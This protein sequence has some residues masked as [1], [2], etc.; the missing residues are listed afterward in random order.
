MY[1]CGYN[2][3]GSQ[4]DVAGYVI[5]NGATHYI[6]GMLN[7]NVPMNGYVAAEIGGTS[8]SPKT[9]LYVIYDWW[10]SKYYKIEN[11]QTISGKTWNQLFTEVTN[12]AN[13][14]V[15]GKVACSW[16][17]KALMFEETT[18]CLLSSIIEDEVNF[19]YQG[20]VANTTDMYADIT[21]YKFSQDANGNWIKTALNDKTVRKWAF[22]L[23]MNAETPNS[24]TAAPVIKLFNGTWWSTVTSGNPAYYNSMQSMMAGDLPA[25][26]GYYNTL[27]LAVPSICGTYIKTLTSNRAFINELFA[28]EITVENMI[29]SRNYNF[30][31]D[32]SGNAILK[33]GT[34]GGIS[35]NNN[36]IEIPFTPTKGLRCYVEYNRNKTNWTTDL[37]EVYDSN[38][39]PGTMKYAMRFGYQVPGL[40]ARIPL[41]ESF[42][43]YAN[44]TSVGYAFSTVDNPY[45]VPSSWT[46]ISKTSFP[47][48]ENISSNYKWLFIREA[49]PSNDSPIIY[50]LPCYT[51]STRS[52]GFEIKRDGSAIFTGNTRFEGGIGIVCDAKDVVRNKSNGLATITY[53]FPIDF[54]VYDVIIFL[55]PN[56]SQGGSVLLYKFTCVQ[57]TNYG[58]PAMSVYKT[59]DNTSGF[60][61]IIEASVEGDNVGYNSQQYPNGFADYQHLWLQKVVIK[62]KTTSLPISSVKAVLIPYME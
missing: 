35:I 25:V 14:V 43:C 38:A 47:N 50:A 59:Y 22:V 9:P 53:H 49:F 26:A 58:K 8:A 54:K 4:A 1:V 13:Y 15:L 6:K 27:G 51:T 46:D 20:V 37:S 52:D 11:G 48:I 10:S 12:K 32:R 17:E 16:V 31:I 45:T 18:P 33:S 61:N 28:N 44:T 21:P 41:E 29:R 7:S 56:T 55:E 60:A 5:V 40:S 36:G 62:Q 34:I 23:C 19:T 30:S 2:S 39:K 24:S 42:V 57:Y 3:S